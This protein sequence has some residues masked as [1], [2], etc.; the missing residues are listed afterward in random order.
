MIFRMNQPL[1]LANDHQDGPA[2]C[3]W[4]S[5]GTGL[6]H[7]IIQRIW[8]F[9]NEH[10]EGLAS[11]KWSSGGTGLLQLIIQRIWTLANDH[12]ED[13]AHCKWSSGGTT[14]LQMIICHPRHSSHLCQDSDSIPRTFLKQFV[15]VWRRPKE[16]KKLF[17]N[18][19]LAF[20]INC[21]EVS[22]PYWKNWGAL[23]STF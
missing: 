18:F 14:L 22:S 12:S 11:C 21:W 20:F 2:S 9:A 13:L 1:A 17:F 5:E 16:E 7:L 10:L 8:L 3:K 4:S 19:F 15:L 6:L 23:F